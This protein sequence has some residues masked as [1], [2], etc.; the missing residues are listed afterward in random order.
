MS[1]QQ[2]LDQKKLSTLGIAAILLMSSL[3]VMVGTAVTPAV[4]ELCRVY[5]LGNYASW[6]IT[7]PALGVVITTV[8]F[9]RII[10]KKGPYWVAFI[11][12]LCYG[13]FG[14][15][16]SLMPNVVTLLLDRLLLGAATAAIKQRRNRLDT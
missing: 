9:G 15:A 6:L 8:L 2:S 12:L 7:T 13:A 16:G 5:Q 4:A 3:T 14:I 11:G 10:D 1:E